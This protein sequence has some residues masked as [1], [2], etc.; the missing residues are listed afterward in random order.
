MSLY[1]E[2]G[3]SP[4]DEFSL[5]CKEGSL[6]EVQRLYEAVASDG[7]LRGFRV[8]CQARRL[9]VAQWVHVQVVG[10]LGA[11]VQVLC[12]WLLS[13]MCG[14]LAKSPREPQ[15]NRQF[16]F[17]YTEDTS[18]VIKWLLTLRSGWPVSVPTFLR[19]VFETR[20]RRWTW[21]AAVVARP[22]SK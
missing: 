19:D 21:I 22:K 18:R 5:H 20:E 7:L 4:E 12:E 14:R 15:F 6:G 17:D 9:E 10:S 13:D 2:L 11:E 8:A 16:W 3:V 1:A